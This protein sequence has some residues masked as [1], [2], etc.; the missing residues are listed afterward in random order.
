MEEQYD[1]I[2]KCFAN[3]DWCIQL[4]DLL[5]PVR[6]EPWKA[7]PL[8]LLLLGREYQKD[9]YAWRDLF[10]KHHWVHFREL[11]LSRM[12]HKALTTKNNPA[13][14]VN[15]AKYENPWLSSYIVVM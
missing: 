14:N 5:W 2:F 4:L 9:V 6:L 12:P 15:S 7:L 13:Q 1:E 10:M 11:E 8:Y 3:C